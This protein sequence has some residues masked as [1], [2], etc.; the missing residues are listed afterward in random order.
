MDFPVKFNA[1]FPC[2]LHL[3][4]EVSHKCT[5]AALLSIYEL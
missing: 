1:G 4:M 2:C 3:D 5:T